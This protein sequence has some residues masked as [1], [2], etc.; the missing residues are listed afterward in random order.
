M[1]KHLLI[2]IIAGLS[3]SQTCNAVGPIT[4][5]NQQLRHIFEHVT[6]PNPIKIG[7]RLSIFIKNNVF[8]ANLYDLTGKL[9]VNLPIAKENGAIFVTIPSVIDC[10]LYFLN[11]QTDEISFQTKLYVY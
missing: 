5:A 3:L 6:N 8:S 10:G 9:V 11:L 1:K 7:E 2:L 4:S